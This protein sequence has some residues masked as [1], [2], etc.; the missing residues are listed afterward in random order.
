[1]KGYEKELADLKRQQHEADRGIR[2]IERSGRKQQEDLDREA[3]FNQVR[4]KARERNLEMKRRVLEQESKTADTFKQAEQKTDIQSFIYIASGAVAL[5]I[6][7]AL[8]LMCLRASGKEEEDWIDQEMAI[9]SQ[10]Q[11]NPT[12]V[13]CTDAP[14]LYPIEPTAH[15]KNPV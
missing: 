10:H 9:T 2:D 8:I 15:V 14:S 12:Y 7:A 6:I 11:V 4:F 3:Q 5:L 13:P 1:M